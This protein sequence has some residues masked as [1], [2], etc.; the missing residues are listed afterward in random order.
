MR[1]Y[2]TIAIIAFG[3]YLTRA[4]PFWFLKN[5]NLTK[6][7]IKIID[8][9]PYA[10]ISLLVVYSFKDTTMA[11]MAPT[12]IAAGVCVGSYMWKENMILSTV[13]ST[14]VYMVLL[15]II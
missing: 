5:Q 15:N 11:N 13:S 1:I 4:L 7:S 2:L 10:T 9:L 6:R 14:L 3:T 8:A 12:I